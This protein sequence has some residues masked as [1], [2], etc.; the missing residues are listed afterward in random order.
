MT[1]RSSEWYERFFKLVLLDR[2]EKAEAVARTLQV[3]AQPG[4]LRAMFDEFLYEVTTS[5]HQST[6][7]YT[8]DNGFEKIVFFEDDETKIK[9]R[10]HI[11]HS[12]T[13][14]DT[15]RVRQNVHN[16]RWDF[17][18]IILLGHV[19]Q[20]R[21]RFA[22]KDE[23]GEDFFHYRYYAR[24]SKEHYD[25]E[26]LGKTRLVPLGSE[27]FEAGQLYCIDNEVLHR[28]DIEDNLAVATLVVTHENVGWVT[29]DLLSERCM[30]VKRVRLQSPAMTKEQIIFK[31]TALRQLLNI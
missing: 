16:H 30:G 12:L 14:P 15:K 11:W 27:R 31:V 21:Y 25:L 7:S 28:V 17:A 10:L 24:G 22:E 2:K 18:S 19:D 4:N 1:L 8:H 29:N 13:I 3:I 6:D 9:M 26:E 20:L 5:V 23:R